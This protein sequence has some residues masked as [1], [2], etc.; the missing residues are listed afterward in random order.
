MT[1]RTIIAT[2]AAFSLVACASAAKHE[3][4]TIPVADGRFHTT[5]SLDSTRVRPRG[6]SVATMPV[7]SIS[8]LSDGGI[9]VKRIQLLDAGNNDLPIV[10]R[11][12]AESFGL[13]FQID[14]NVHGSV[15]TRLQDVTLEQALD[16]IVLPQGYT[17]SID[18]GVLRVGAAKVQ[19]KIFSL[20]YVAM[21][22]FA[23]T[24]TS[25]S[26]RVGG[27]GGGGGSDQIS[28]V[29]VTDLWSDLRT[30]LVA[31]I[32]DTPNRVP[33]DTTAVTSTGGV[34]NA[35][36]AAP[37]STGQGGGGGSGATAFSR[38][39]GYGQRLIINPVAGTVLV[40]AN[41]G[42]LAEVA[43]F[44]QAFESSVQRQVL[45]EAK[46]VEVRLNNDFQFGIDWSRIAS[47][48]NGLGFQTSNQTG[49]PTVT[50][51]LGGGLSKINV[52][53]HALQSQG[54]VSV[55]SSPRVAAMNNM[56]ATFN[57]TTDEVFFIVNSTP[58]T[59]ANGV[60]GSTQNV[61]PQ[62]I[63]V[64]IVLD[65]LPQ[66][67]ADNIITMN[68]RPH[69]TSVVRVAEFKTENGGIITAPVVENRETDTMIRARAGETVVIGGLMQNAITHT[70]SGVP[71]LQSLPV[72]G[73]LF[74]G[75]TTSTSKSELVIFITAT[76][77]A[78]QPAIGY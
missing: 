38:V 42:K 22:R 23:S 16:A 68:I 27:S 70:S 78:G 17:Y 6:D 5:V 31:L 39:D 13:N 61:T 35:S 58:I 11:G 56:R 74:R 1:I 65:V 28:S 50:L 36:S 3:P 24:S 64:G 75:K 77:V 30:S 20:D 63:S 7:L 55:L 53:L 26:R 66:I 12:L 34:T 19:T 10:L 49:T 21:S 25:V 4:Q 32:F 46:I 57:V 73:G 54:D 71:G 76:I 37:Q 15:Q 45:I 59:N 52:V 9:P 43:T 18:N 29:S 41:P 60:V 62:T 2:A 8:Q 40:T 51:S 72:V 69:V 67:A 47:G 48:T 14:A 44:M 33:G